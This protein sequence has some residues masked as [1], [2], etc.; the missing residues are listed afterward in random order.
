[1][2]FQIWPVN[3]LL[4]IRS[5]SLAGFILNVPILKKE[6]LL[7]GKNKRLITLNAGD[8]ENSLSLYCNLYFICFNKLYQGNSI[9]WCINR[10][11]WLNRKIYHCRQLFVCGG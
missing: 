10:C 2:C 7:P 8:N 1:M 6:P 5:M 9:G 3:I 11:R 4:K